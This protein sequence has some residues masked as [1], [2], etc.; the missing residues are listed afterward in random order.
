MPKNHIRFTFQI[1]NDGGSLKI[2]DF[3]KEDLDDVLK[4]VEESFVEEFEIKGFDPDVWRKIVRRRYSVGGR[5]IF[6]FL[7]LL[8]KE[9]IRFF[10]A[11]ENGKVVGTI[12]I[13]KRRKLGYLGTV[14][15]HPDFR[16]KGIATKLMETAINYAR[17][18]KIANTILHVIS[19]NNPAKG[20][21]QKLGFKKF[22]EIVFL[23]AD[24]DSFMS[25]KGAEGIQVRDFQKSDIDAVYEL[26]K[27]SRDADWLKVYDFKKND[28]KP[29]RLER[30]AR[31]STVRK[32]VAV[33]EEKIVGY[34]FLSYT[35]PKEAA[36][37]TRIDVSSEMVSKG[38]V[39][40]VIRESVNQFKSSGAKTIL[41]IVP[42]TKEQ[43]IEIL[44]TMGFKK[45]LVMEGMVI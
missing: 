3:R 32:I 24:M 7:G 21:Y 35:T 16:R 23:T 19:T 42:Q 25:L 5:I 2:R 18:R 38:I 10:I 1:Q 27:S 29:S 17:K 33:I 34:A 22:E 30:I 11:E 28:L 14:T 20:L 36:R 31:M 40:E 6:G 15:V 9:P 39:E 37:I 12:M 45:R 8:R 4:C 44:E 13:E 26:I 43:L 41:A